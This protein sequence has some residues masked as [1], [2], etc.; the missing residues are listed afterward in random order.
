MK[1]SDIFEGT[2][3]HL[4]DEIRSALNNGDDYTAKQY[5][6]MA[7]TPEERKRLMAMIRKAMRS[8]VSESATSNFPAARKPANIT[9]AIDELV[10]SW[11]NREEGPGIKQRRMNARA[12][13]EDM[14]KQLTTPV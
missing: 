7:S 13:L 14:I 2:D 5:A 6:K 4:E 8:E 10:L 12:Q 1:L 11:M 3:S 9:Q